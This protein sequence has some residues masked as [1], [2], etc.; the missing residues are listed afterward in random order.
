GG[1]STHFRGTPTPPCSARSHWSNAQTSA[2]LKAVGRAIIVKLRRAFLFSCLSYACGLAAALLPRAASAVIIGTGDGSQNTTQGSM[3]AGWNY[4]GS[5]S[6]AGGVYLGNRW[7]ITAAH[8]GSI[9]SGAPFV[10]P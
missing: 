9:P 6:S 2:I 5:I 10:L 3:P 8:V 1:P 7:G 4:V